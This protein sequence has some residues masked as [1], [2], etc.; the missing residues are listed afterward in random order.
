MN[1]TIRCEKFTTEKAVPLELIDLEPIA[2]V[3]VGDDDV[4]ESL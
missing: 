2:T 4:L 1:Q 3:P